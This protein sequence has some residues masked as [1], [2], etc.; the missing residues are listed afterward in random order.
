MSVYKRKDSKFW[1][2]NVCRGAGLPRLQG[3][4][5]KTDKEEARA[6]EQVVRMAYRKRGPRDK[7]VALI[8]ALTG[9]ARPGLPLAG[10]FEAYDGWM[11]STGRSVADITR[12]LRRRACERFADW[13]SKNWPSAANAGDVD[14]SC[15]AGFASW[16]EKEG[17][18]GKTRR[19]VIGDLGTVWEGL[20][21]VRDDVKENPWPLVLPQDDSERLEP[22]TR[23]QEK[24]VLKAAD[25]AGWGLACRIAR[26]TGLRYGDVARLTWDRID[27]KAGVVRVDPGKTARHGIG[28]AVPLCGRLRKAL[29]AAKAEGGGRGA[30]DGTGQGHV[31][32]D[33]ARWYPT[34]NKGPM[35]AFAEVLKK[36]KVD[37]ATHTFHSWRHTFR[38]RLSEAGVSDEIA[39]RLGGW[40]E[41]AT[42]M[43]YD[44]DGRGKELAD[45]VE[46]SAD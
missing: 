43:R 30:E 13:A 11:R 15:A 20:R 21:R 28:V 41:D 31:L 10:V 40:T 35:G 39:K 9:G 45:A 37:C 4:T 8:D 38:T 44:H 24:A 5:G 23:A 25:K 14:R 34:P 7:L 1:W 33:H 19:N 2:F 22:F 32:P 42:A 17:T 16:L 12:R 36:A 18:A 26:H 6:V 3:S 46:R 29:E 27:L